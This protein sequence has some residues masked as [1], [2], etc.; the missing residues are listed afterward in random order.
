MYTITIKGQALPGV[1]E[2]F[3]RPLQREKSDLMPPQPPVPPI[4][5]PQDPPDEDMVD[6]DR[7]GPRQDMEHDGARYPSP[8]PTAYGGP[9]PFSDSAPAPRE[10]SLYYKTTALMKMETKLMMV[11]I[12]IVCD[13]VKRQ[14]KPAAGMLMFNSQHNGSCIEGLVVASFCNH[15]VCQ[16]VR[17]GSASSRLSSPPLL[18][19]GAQGSMRLCVATKYTLTPHALPLPRSFCAVCF[20][21]TPSLPISLPP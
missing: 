13:R 4:N 16:T 10:C 6:R 19:N 2:S 18:L 8:P 7:D 1:P 17:L 20:S 3:L 11:I 14:C 15:R 21:T 9:T 12:L 5:A